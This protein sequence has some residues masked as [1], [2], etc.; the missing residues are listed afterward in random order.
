M[1]KSVKGII[2]ILLVF[3]V[4]LSSVSVIG[5]FAKNVDSSGGL[6][7]V[8]YDKGLSLAWKKIEGAK[9]YRI[10]K[11]DPITQKWSL[12][13]GIKG[14]LYRD[15]RVMN[16]F[17]Y[18]YKL[19]YIDKNGE[20][21]TFKQSVSERY[22]EA[23]QVYVSCTPNAAMVSWDSYS[24]ATQYRIYKKTA[25]STSWQYLRSVGSSTKYIMDYNVSSGTKYIYTVRQVGGEIQGCYDL[26]G[27]STIFRKAP[28]VTAKHSPKGVVLNWSSAGANASYIIDQRSEANTTWETV[29]NVS[30][31]VTFTCPYNKIDFGV[32]NYFRIRVKGT[33]QVSYSTWVNGIDPNKPMVAL[34]YDDGPHATVTDDIVDVL[35]KYNARATFF[36]VGNRVGSYKSALKHSVAAGCEIGNHTYGHYIL[37]NYGAST[38]KSQIAQTNTAIRNITGVT[39]TLVR[40]PGGSFN[41][42]VKAN[43]G[44]PLIQWSV[45]TLDWKTRKSGSVISSVKSSVKDGSIILMHDLYPTTAAATGT[46]VPWLSQQGYQ[47]VTVTELLQIRGYDLKPGTVYYN[48][49]KK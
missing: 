14:S 30:K 21:N 35:E 33:N 6:E 24:T 46:I 9:G 42:S 5:A 15:T 38:I 39:P 2:S 27:I 10:N 8:N 47:M 32:V 12:V 26:A 44:Y 16:G 7:V 18:T 3:L 17:T 20:I 41:S 23:P 25:N 28:T 45:D 29:G 4:L 37:T 31:K 34:T 1:R 13:I 22:L 48:G 19:S 43:V 49:Y 36:V 40:A 11:Y